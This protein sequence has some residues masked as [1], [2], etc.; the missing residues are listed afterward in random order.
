MNG[1]NFQLFREPIEVRELMV[2]VLPGKN[3]DSATVLLTINNSTTISELKIRLASS[4]E[5]EKDR[6]LLLFG[7]RKLSNNEIIPEDAYE[8]MQQTKDDLQ[9]FRPRICLYVI[10]LDEEVTDNI[11]ERLR[12]PVVQE[13][14]QIDDTVFSD[15]GSDDIGS[16]ELKHEKF[17]RRRFNLLDELVAIDCSQFFDML[18]KN[19]YNEEVC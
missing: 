14:Q 19:G 3:N 18:C 16:H 12:T 13:M 9:L 17:T 5:I 6:M 15:I 10:P 8:L 4:T 11:Q 2:R 1:F 7:G